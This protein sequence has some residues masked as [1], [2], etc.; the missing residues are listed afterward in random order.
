MC[1]DH[2]ASPSCSAASSSGGRAA[3]AMLRMY[4]FGLAC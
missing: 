3:C 2:H 1:S 4:R